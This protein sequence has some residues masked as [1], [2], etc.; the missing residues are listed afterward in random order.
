[1]HARGGEN[2][3]MPQPTPYIDT[4][5][6]AFVNPAASLLLGALKHD[7]RPPNPRIPPTKQYENSLQHLHLELREARHQHHVQ[8]RSEAP[9]VHGCPV[10]FSPPARLFLH[11]WSQVRGRPHECPR[12]GASHVRIHRLRKSEVKELH[13][14]VSK[15]FEGHDSS[16][17]HRGTEETARK[18]L[19]PSPGE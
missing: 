16:Q 3:R 12:H 5:A 9:A 4:E 19:L 1:M 17:H 2:G 8:H 7:S 6:S 15:A 10:G 13:L 11:F 18:H 14:E